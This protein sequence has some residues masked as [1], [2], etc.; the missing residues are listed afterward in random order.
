M[1]QLFVSWQ[2]AFVTHIFC[3]LYKLRIINCLSF[4]FKEPHLCDYWFFFFFCSPLT[5]LWCLSLTIYNLSINVMMTLIK[6]L[7]LNELTY[8]KKHYRFQRFHLIKA[9]I[10]CRLWNLPRECLIPKILYKLSS[11]I[12]PESLKNKCY[13][14]LSSVVSFIIYVV[15]GGMTRHFWNNM[16]NF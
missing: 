14:V 12:G 5:L 3:L 8:T 2:K 1:L 6:M 10:Y 7:I 13:L 11:T 15:N 16:I 4:L 9:K